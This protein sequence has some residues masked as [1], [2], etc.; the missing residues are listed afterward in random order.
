MDRNTLLAFTLSM[1]VFT[2][3]LMWQAEQAPPREV[4]PATAEQQ[5]PV[6]GV[7]K[8][9]E[10]LPAVAPSVTPI[11]PLTTAAPVA[12]VAL[13]TVAEWKRSFD[14]GLYRVE[15][16]NRGGGLTSWTLLD[17]RYVE[18]VGGQER[19]IQLLKL[20]G[21]G[22]ALRT[23]FLELGL[24]DLSDAMYRVESAGPEDV[25]FVLERGGVL[26]RK[27]YRFD[28]S[29]YG[30]ELEVEVRNDSGG[31][32]RPRFEIVWPAA[33]NAEQDF[34][35]QSLIALQAGDVER[36]MVS[37]VGGGG[38]FDSL[39]GGGSEGPPE[40]HGDIEWAGVDIKYFV[41]VLV[42]ERTRSAQ[43]RFE[44][45]VPSKIGA[46]ILGFEAL[47]LPSGQ[48]L[49]HRLR[50]YIGPKEPER[51]IEFGAGLERSIDRGYQ[52]VTPLTSFFQWLLT[53][54]YSVI[55]NFGVAI[56]LITILVRVVT[57]PIMMRQMRSMERMREV[58]PQLKELQEKHKD[59]KAKQSEEMMKLYKREGVNPL[60]G[61]LPMVLQFPVFIGLFFALKSSISLRHAPFMLWIDDLSAPE[62]LFMIPGLEV[63]VRVLPIVMGASMVLQ[64]RIT[65]MTMDPAQARM[66]MTV[67]PIMMTVLFYQF[68]SGLVLYWMISNFLG[69]GHQMWVGKRLRASK[70]GKSAGTG[71]SGKPGELKEQAGDASTASEQPRP[72]R[73][74]R[75]KRSGSRSRAAKE[76][77]A[78]DDTTAGGLQQ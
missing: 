11:E 36:E 64:Q 28:S 51:L 27:Q 68:P 24:G 3:W 61:C 12:A 43:V 25:S 60:G 65:P 53:V 58:Q 63:P 8:A 74:R 73:K 46:T 23:P 47:D 33:V 18:R 45:L 75:G 1:G 4:Y 41:G 70:A 30:F 21:A 67:M 56:V 77:T 54:F 14:L 44:P 55:P 13:E 22:T 39:F 31:I 57:A 16:T 7:V 15:A 62:S 76:S 5:A 48:A 26:V 37:A 32:L 35:E 29:G 38:F 71:G 34:N 42:P 17:P 40:F 52:W 59:D 6:D 2:L 49:T 20:D 78:T 69:I 9:L 66:M 72:N 50:G 19:P 10:T